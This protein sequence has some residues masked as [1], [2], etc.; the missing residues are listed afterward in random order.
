MILKSIREGLDFKRLA[1]GLNVSFLPSRHND[2]LLKPLSRTSATRLLLNKDDIFQKKLIYRLYRNE[3]LNLQYKQCSN[4][5]LCQI[6]GK[7][8]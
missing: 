2:L 1:Y 7:N 8:N 3:N 5:Y 4:A 6:N